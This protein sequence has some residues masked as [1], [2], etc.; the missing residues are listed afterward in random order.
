[1]R[2]MGDI[3]AT[4]DSRSRYSLAVMYRYKRKYQRR[5]TGVTEKKGPENNPY[6]AANA[7]R[8]A[9]ANEV[10]H[11]AR[12]SIEAI[13]VEIYRILNLHKQSVHFQANTSLQTFL[14]GLRL[15]L[16]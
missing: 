13:R 15:C 10:Y 5:L 1:M 6:S 9:C 12:F 3:S 2:S 8:L 11:R 14:P 7:I 4:H 16:D